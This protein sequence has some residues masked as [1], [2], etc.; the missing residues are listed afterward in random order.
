MNRRLK[1]YPS[2]N[3][4]RRLSGNLLGA[5]R[6]SNKQLTVV[7]MNPAVGQERPVLKT[8]NHVFQA[9]GMDWDILLTKHTRDGHWLAQK[10][11]MLGAKTIAVYGGDG[12]VTDVASGLL[13]SHIPLGIIP[14][15]TTNMIAT[16][17]GIPRDTQQACNLIAQPNPLTRKLYLGQVNHNPFVQMVGIGME[18][19]I[20]EGADRE[21][22]D[23]LGLLAY[24]LAALNALNNPPVTNY[25]MVLDGE[26]VDVEG[27]SC[28]ILNV[29]NLNIPFL[30]SIPPHPR[31]GLLDIFLVR[32]IDLRSFISVAAT[33]VGAGIDLEILPHWQARQ[34]TIATDSPQPVQGDGEMLGQTPISVKVVSQYTSVIIPPLGYQPGLMD[35]T[36]M[37]DPDLTP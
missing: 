6:R 23:R 28:L 32:K 17:L 20:I 29:D 2:V 11:V 37:P 36:S 31:N 22:K 35:A 26:S 34:I 10:S 30:S 15:G 13:G 4:V 24:G 9:A 3:L 16:T 19:R 21:A 25:H 5:W 1:S 7:I 27:V 18:A 33:M 8:I 12:T 14:G